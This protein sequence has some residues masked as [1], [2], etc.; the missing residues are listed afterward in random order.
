MKLSK[1]V[2]QIQYQVAKLEVLELLFALKDRQGG[3]LDVRLAH[4][5]MSTLRRTLAE[6]CDTCL[7][8]SID[9]LDQHRSRLQGTIES[10]NSYLGQM[11]GGLPPADP[12]A[13]FVKE[14][15]VRVIS[16]LLTL[17]SY[18]D[19]SQEEIPF[20]L[21]VNLDAEFYPDAFPQHP[22]A[23][24]GFDQEFDRGFDRGFNQG[25]EDLELEILSDANA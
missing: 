14:V 1:T 23:P 15:I 5:M 17:S 20:Q 13:L 7:A 2:N 22:V 10:V 6:S 19:Q 24:H 4:S 16:E 3:S 8:A 11:A 18:L 25:S 12:Q 9:E 21:P